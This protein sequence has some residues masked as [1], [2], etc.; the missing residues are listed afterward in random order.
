MNFFAWKSANALI[1]INNWIFFISL[2]VVNR[3]ELSPLQRKLADPTFSKGA[4]LSSEEHVAWLNSILTP[5]SFLNYAREVVSGFNLCVYTH[6]QSCLTQEINKNLINIFNSGLLNSWTKKFVDR[7]FLMRITDLRPH[8]LSFDK[9]SGAYDVL[10]IGLS[11]SFL[12]FICEII[13]AWIV[14]KCKRREWI[15]KNFSWCSPG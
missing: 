3:S 2:K 8:K 15:L 14:G 5:Y 12:V 9:L 13:Y 4:L 1:L 11:I 10:I 6:I 7:S